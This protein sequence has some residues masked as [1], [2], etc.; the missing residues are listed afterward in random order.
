MSQEIICFLPCRKGSERIPQKKI[1]PFSDH[2]N[3]LIE[4]KIQQLLGAKLVDKIIVSTNDD[5]IIK[6]VTEIDSAKICLHHREEYLS[7]GTTST[8]DLIL[9]ALSLIPDG[10]ILWT[11]VTSPFVTS[12]H[13]DEVVSR[14]LDALDEGYDSLM[15]TTPIR[16]FYGIKID[17]LIII[18]SSKNGHRHKKLTPVHE[19][20]NGVFIASSNI[21]REFHDR[22]GDAPYL[23]ALD[24]IVSH[25]IDWP[26][27]FVMAEL[28]VEKGLAEL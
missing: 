5:E 1:K 14:Y 25:D 13:Y 16:S 27:D 23:Y 19:I 21:Y 12:R 2:E 18:V 24:K 9:H 22:I 6:F 4:I 20:N 8:D 26:E 10:H 3:G 15:T 28:F 11:H 17:Q 7:S